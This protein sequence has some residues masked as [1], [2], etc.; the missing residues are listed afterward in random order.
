MSNEV[1][2]ENEEKKPAQK[3][4]EETMH[5]LA[6]LVITTVS[7]ASLVISIATGMKGKRRS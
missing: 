6:N 3:L 4:S 2:K 1:I 7:V 5:I